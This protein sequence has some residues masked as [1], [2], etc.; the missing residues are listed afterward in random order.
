MF[1]L[2]N[3]LC[4]CISIIAANILSD[5]IV[6]ELIDIVLPETF[7]LSQN[8]PNPFNPHTMI[9]FSLGAEELVS[10]KIY[11]IQGRLVKS[12][13]NNT[14][15]PAGYHQSTWDGKNNMGTHLPSGMYFYTLVSDH[16]TI[17]KKMVMMK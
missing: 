2:F 8:Y 6:I 15:F 10:L 12:L 14:Y 5:V 16:R 11:D 13:I 9:Q 7:E 4:F 3:K 17:T 1:P